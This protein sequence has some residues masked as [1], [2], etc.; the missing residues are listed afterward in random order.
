M[1]PY[2]LKRQSLDAY[3]GQTLWELKEL[4]AAQ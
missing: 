1:N 3:D 2:P 4:S